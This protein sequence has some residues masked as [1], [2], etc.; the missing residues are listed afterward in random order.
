MKYGSTYP[1]RF[2]SIDEARVWLRGFV[3]WY[4]HEHKH[5]GIAFLPPEIVHSGR[6]PEVLAQRQVTLDV[7]YARNPERYPRGRPQVAQIPAQVGI[8]LPILSVA[9]TTSGPAEAKLADEVGARLS[10]DL[11]PLDPTSAGG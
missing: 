5:S 9:P 7:A 3:A 11:P 6:A 1:N 2:A 10:A 8:N 4:N